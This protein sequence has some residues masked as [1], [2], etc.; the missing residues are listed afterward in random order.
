MRIAA[1]SLAAIAFALSLAAC[2]GSEEQ[3]VLETMSDAF[4]DHPSTEEIDAAL[5]PAFAATT[6]ADTT[7]NRERAGNVLVAL[8]EQNGGSEMDILACIPTLSGG[9]LP[10]SPF[11]EVAAL[12]S[13]SDRI[14][15]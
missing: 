7:E 13:A 12:C 10:T 15:E 4:V 6:T 9:E 14:L 2:G 3:K 5:T 8:R 11:H 1:W